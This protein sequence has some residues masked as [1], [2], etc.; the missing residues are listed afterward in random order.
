MV[1][2]QIMKN[3]H[4]LKIEH[5]TPSIR[6]SGVPTSSLGQVSWRSP[7]Q[8]FIKINCDAA[9]GSYFSSIVV[10]T[11]DWRGNLVF[12]FSKKVN[13]II[14]LQVDAEALLWGG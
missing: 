14:P 11:R 10:V 1:V 7:E 13:N 3:L 2:V 4:L 9:V 5:G 6:S 8:E 12:A